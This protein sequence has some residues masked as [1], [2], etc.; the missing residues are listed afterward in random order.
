MSSS[1]WWERIGWKRWQ[2]DQW[3]LDDG[4]IQKVM[5][6]GW[7]LDDGYIQEVMSAGFQEGKSIFNDPLYFKRGTQSK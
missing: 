2:C 1:F 6:A 3:N 4:Y 7:N 5:S